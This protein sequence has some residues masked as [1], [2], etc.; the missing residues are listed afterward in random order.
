MIIL[1]LLQIPGEQGSAQNN[2]PTIMSVADNHHFVRRHFRL[3]KT[4]SINR[5]ESYL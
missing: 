5:H 4:D 1:L 3:A 2:H